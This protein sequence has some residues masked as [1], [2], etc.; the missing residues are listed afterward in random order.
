MPYNRN[1]SRNYN[2]P[3]APAPAV[4]RNW[5]VQQ[6]AIFEE[7]ASGTENVEVLALAGTGKTTTILVGIERAPERKILLAAFNNIIAGELKSRLRNP[8]AEAKTLHALGNA[9]IRAHWGN[10]DLDKVGERGKRLARQAAFETVGAHAPFPAITLIKQLASK[11][12]GICPA[13]TTVEDLIDVA[14]EF[15]LAPGW[16]I[17]EEGWDIET[18][19]RAT[20][21]AMDLATR[22]EGVID[23]DD[24]IFIP[25]RLGLANPMY[26]LVVIDEAQDMNAAQ[27]SLAQSV[28]TKNGRIFVVGDSH[29]AIYGFRGADSGCMARLATELKAKILPLTVTYRCGARIV[30]EARRLV[31]EFESA[32]DAFPGEVALCSEHKMFAAAQGGDFI[33]SRKN[34]PLGPLCLAFLREGRPAMIRGKDIGRGLVSLIR[35]IDATDLPGLF[36]G[37]DEW[38]NK[39]I[40]SIVAKATD[41]EIDQAKVAFISDQ[42]ETIKALAEGASDP[43][44]V[45]SRLENLFSDEVAA[46]KIILSSV[47]KAKGLEADTVYLLKDTFRSDEGEEGNIKYVAITRAKRRLVWVE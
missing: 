6:Q 18:I 10:V 32:P 9:I 14:V 23:F 12:K 22:N 15:N 36:H 28:V 41:N 13:D 46:G 3:V 27:L 35:K 7:F 42:A 24:M 34:A 17:E 30:D 33:L 11:G 38:A 2:R 44:E 40:E 19:A 31:P 21:R 39:M 16:Q 8:R 26:D 47:H 43:A 1:Y 20:L 29:Q 5:S 37:L 25:V 45:S 4:E